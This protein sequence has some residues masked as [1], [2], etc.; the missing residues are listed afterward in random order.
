M[1]MS[2][3]FRLHKP[4]MIVYI[5]DRG[6]TEGGLQ[7]FELK[8][9]EVSTLGEATALEHEH[10]SKWMSRV[11]DGG[12]APPPWAVGIGS[13]TMQ[14]LSH[15]YE[16]TGHADKVTSHEDPIAPKEERDKIDVPEVISGPWLANFLGAVLGLPV[17]GVGDDPAWYMLGANWDVQAAQDLVAYHGKS[18]KKDLILTFTALVKKNYDEMPKDSVV[19]VG[20]RK[21]DDDFKYS[22]RVYFKV[23]GKINA[24]GEGEEQ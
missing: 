5:E 15:L 4:V 12:Y 18:A 22:F 20:V 9:Q 23:K 3:E 14:L 24:V 21:C 19:A 8:V 7:E 6:K 11:Q 2:V 13:P 17:H 10:L 16:L 1:V